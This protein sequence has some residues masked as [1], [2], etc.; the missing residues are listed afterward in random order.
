[1]PPLFLRTLIY[2]PP[3][4]SQRPDPYHSKSP[5][6][7]TVEQI[8]SDCTDEHGDNDSSSMA[9]RSWRRK[10]SAWWLLSVAPFSAIAWSAP[11]APRVEV[12]TWLACKV[13]RPDV[14]NSTFSPFLG[15]EEAPSAHTPFDVIPAFGLARHHI[16]HSLYAS[17]VVA[18]GVGMPPTVSSS[19]HSRCTTDPV[20]QAAVA[21]L[22]AVIA[23]TTGILSCLTAAWWGILSDKYGRTR[24]LGIA[25]IARLVSDFLLVFV[26]LYTDNFPGGYWFLTLGALLEGIFGGA[27]AIE[28]AE[29]GYYADTTTEGNR[30]RIFSLNY[31]LAY[32]GLAVGPALG[33]LLMRF[34]GS[35]LSVFYLTAFLHI[36]TAVFCRFIMPESLT[37]EKMQESRTKHLQDSNHIGNGNPAKGS[38]TSHGLIRSIFHFFSPLSLFIPRKASDRQSLGT[39]RRD[40]SLAF[41]AV[42]YGFCTSLIGSYSYKVQYSVAAFGWKT[43]Q[44]GY[45]LSLVFTTR[46]VVLIVVLPIILQYLKSKPMLTQGHA[47]PSEETSLLNSSS[48]AASPNNQ[49]KE[50]YSLSINILTARWS[51]I[52]EGAS[53]IFTGLSSTALPYIFFSVTEAMSVS[54]I[55]TAQALAL[56]IYTRS[57]GT[58]SGRLFGALSV[59]RGI[60]T[61]II[62][63][64]IYGSVYV[65]TVAWFPRGIFFTF[66]MS[67]LVSLV[68]LSMV[69]LPKDVRLD[70]EGGG[71]NVDI[72]EQQ[73]SGSGDS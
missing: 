48:Q 41:M 15:S 22:A 11:T 69:R 40:W 13:H 34:T 24:V 64:S 7:C 30:S 73:A 38:A 35:P 17:D 46:A 52:I 2:S 42:S 59:V 47:R 25:N 60:C 21:K 55:P 58:E 9:R 61:D 50:L 31:G 37:K 18:A 71:T 19:E 66:A 27:P 33:S 1:M 6:S 67:I 3:F 72:E 8:E 12:Y 54:F 14:Y 26:T 57:G 5:S 16:P 62:G 36:Y 29:N 32:I 70:M 65:H 51:L 63:P 43:E 39:A 23:T 20:V 56:A 28:A 68:F 10:P 45:W 44:V 49:D 4:P 53:Y